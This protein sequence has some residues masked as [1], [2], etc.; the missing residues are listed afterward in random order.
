VHRYNNKYGYG[1]IIRDFCGV[2][3]DVPI[4]GEVQHSL[5]LNTRYFSSDGRIGPPREQLQRFPRLLSW[6]TLLPFPHQI[7]IGDP[8][9]YANRDTGSDV[10]DL[11]VGRSGADTFSVFMPKL[12]NEVD[13]PDRIEHY[14]AGAREARER[15]TASRLFVA[16]HPRERAH[17]DT[18]ENAE[19]VWAPENFPGGSVAWSQALI[20]QSDAVFSDYFGAHVFRASHFH[21]VRVELVGSG[22][23]NP[24]FHPV[25]DATFRDFLDAHGDTSA[26]KTISE[27][28]LGVEYLKTP[29]EL[30]DIAGFRGWKRIM[31]RPVRVGY[32]RVRR[33]RVAKRRRATAT[34]G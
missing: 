30:A 28:L 13:R 6:N 27:Q 29:E 21:N 22:H 19:L 20:A 11:G 12:N 10:G 15:N 14:V 17:K 2:G 24:G 31:G 16:L 3:P 8:L 7:P 1:Q 34:R 23:F 26:Q 33:A 4:W 5:F 32:Q 25:M 18:M 9:L